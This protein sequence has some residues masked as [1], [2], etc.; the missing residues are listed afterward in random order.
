MKIK[1]LILT[2]CLIVVVGC[3]RRI[4]TL[5]NGEEAIITFNNGQMIS[6]DEFYERLKN[7]MGLQILTKMMD[8]VILESAFPDRLEDARES[9]ELTIQSIKTQFGDGALNALQQFTGYQTFEAYEEYLYIAFLQDLA[10]RDFAKDQITDRNINNYYRDEI[11]GDIRVSHILIVPEAIT[12]MSP[13]EI[14]EVELEAKE[15]AE[16]LIARLRNVPAR[17]VAEKFAELAEEYSDDQRTGALGG[18]MGFINKHTLP[19]AYQN[20]AAEAYKLRDGAFTTS[21]VQSDLGFHIILRV[22]S[23]EKPELDD[24]L[25]EEILNI[26]GNRL[27]EEDATVSIRAMQELRNDFGFEIIDSELQ[28]QYANFIQTLLYTAERINRENQGN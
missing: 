2:L 12:G 3:G 25:R 8:T 10:I 11:K 19:A 28:T 9:A 1:I 15:K 18:D 4:P 21:V 7:D 23:K 16:E 13:A 14:E 17:D 26:L 20:F 27:I 22:E 5:Q 24:D 6:V